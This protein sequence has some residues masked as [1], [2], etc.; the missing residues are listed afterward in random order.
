M[1][2][3]ISISTG[4]VAAAAAAGSP[5][6][7]YPVSLSL[8]KKHLRVDTSRFDDLIDVYL[9]AAIEWIENATHRTVLQREHLWILRD[10][11]RDETAIRLPRG[12]TVSVASIVYTD[13]DE[14]TTLTG[15]TS[16]VA[17]TDYQEDLRGD[18]G[19]IL[20]PPSGQSWPSVDCDAPAPVVITF[21]AGPAETAAD[22][23]RAILFLIAD[24]ITMPGSADMG[25]GRQADAINAIVSPYC[26]HRF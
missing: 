24:H 5:P 19:G 12:K 13:G 23:K 20:T 26:L 7:G 3:A 15:P 17:G 25:S 10:F 18:D 14:Q 6:L 22:L 21:T 1:I 9:P 2:E 4:S 11:P 16:Q 8:I